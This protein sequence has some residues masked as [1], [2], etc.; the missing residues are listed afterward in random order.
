MVHGDRES[1]H[2]EDR[3]GRKRHNRRDQQSEREQR[4][5]PDVVRAQ[6]RDAMGRRRVDRIIADASR[7]SPPNRRRSRMPR[8]SAGAQAET[9]EQQQNRVIA[10]A[11]RCRDVARRNH[12]INVGGGDVE[13]Q[14]R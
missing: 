7:L 9:C 10:D 6:Q 2:E 5:E 3:Q 4:A 14:G 11:D 13:R 1:H 12:P 8:I